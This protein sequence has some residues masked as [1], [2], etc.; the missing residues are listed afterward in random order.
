MINLVSWTGRGVAA[1]ESGFVFMRFLS[2]FRCR[3][4]A[5]VDQAGRLS[6]VIENQKTV[7]V[8]NIKLLAEVVEGE[9][10]NI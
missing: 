8:N 6:C 7:V 10:D 4:A 3:R 5:I 1:C 9:T 2:M